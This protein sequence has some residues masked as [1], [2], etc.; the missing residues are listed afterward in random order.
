MV[1]GGKLVNFTNLDTLSGNISDVV[2][3]C[4]SPVE[5]ESWKGADY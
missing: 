2:V 3:F 1:I 5:L 4:Q